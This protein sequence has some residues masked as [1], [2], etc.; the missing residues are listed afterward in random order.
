MAVLNVS[1][2]EVSHPPVNATP[3]AGR[4]FLSEK[5]AH[6]SFSAII[7]GFRGLAAPASFAAAATILYIYI[8]H[9]WFPSRKVR[10][11]KLNHQIYV[12]KSNPATLR[13]LEFPTNCTGAA[14]AFPL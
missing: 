9:T 4:T 13:R 1:N 5:G 10:E 14:G 6:G 8:Y 7:G 2:S 12:D 3:H 11:R